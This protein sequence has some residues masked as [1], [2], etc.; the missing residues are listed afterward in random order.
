[1]ILLLGQRNTAVVTRQFVTSNSLDSVPFGTKP[2]VLISLGRIAT[3]DSS[4]RIS[5]PLAQDWKKP[6]HEAR[7]LG[8]NQFIFQ[9]LHQ[10]G[11]K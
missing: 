8:Y 10:Q 2:A 1:M 5:R 7:K 3:A 11:K 4:F 9:L 6:V